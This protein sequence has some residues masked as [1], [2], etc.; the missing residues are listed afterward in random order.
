[1]PKGLNSLPLRGTVGHDGSVISRPASPEDLPAATELARRAD[2]AWFGAPER[3]QD[4]IGEYFEQVADFETGS[5]MFFDGGRLVAVAL[6]NDTDA[7]FETDPD[8]EVTRRV[9]DALIGWYAGFDKPKMEALDRNFA[10]RSA[11]EA[12]GWRHQRSS[13]E[14]MREVT[15]GWTLDVPSYPPGVEVRDFSRD[16]AEAMYHLIYVDA[17]WADVPGHPHREFEGWRSLFITESTAPEQQVLAWR[18]DRLV[19][20]SIGRIFSDGMGWIAQLAVARNE[21]GNGLGRA[22]LLDALRLRRDGGATML[23]LQVQ[24][25]NRNALNLYLDAGLHIDREWME[26]RPT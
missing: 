4:E 24:A 17:G 26:Y 9:S 12:H 21:R 25:D 10:M 19:G 3:D 8:Q 18:G 23:G 1:V 11:L 22:L 6:R 15:D 14:L 13:F 16:D 2:T 5:R 7:W 20:V